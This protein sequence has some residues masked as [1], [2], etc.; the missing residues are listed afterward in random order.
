MGK[1]DKYEEKPA[2]AAG[3]GRAIVTRDA[4]VEELARIESAAQK[5][6]AAGGPPSAVKAPRVA[7]ALDATGSMASLLQSAKDAM[8]E[9]MRRVA[10]ELGRP[11]EVELIIYRDYDVAQEL[12]SRSGRSTDHAKLA[13]WLSKVR[14]MGGGSNEGEAIEAALAPILLDGTFACV[15]LAGDEPP[16]HVRSIKAAGRP[17]D[18]DA[19]QIARLLGERNIP[20]H[21]FVVGADSRTIDAFAKLSEL[22]GGKSGRLDGTRE[23]IDLAVLAILASIKGVDAA[24]RYADSISLTRNTQAFADA[25]LLEGP[26]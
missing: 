7:M 6:A 18:L 11:L 21:S 12:L 26:R 2:L 22:S 5:T 10:A 24:R 16:N 3:P 13:R 17:N 4:V 15:L 8:S 20:V 1:F 25:L 19:M 9:I 14:A 23:M